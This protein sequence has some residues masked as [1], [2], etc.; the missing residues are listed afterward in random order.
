LTIVRSQKSLRRRMRFMDAYE[1]F[2]AAAE[3][4][5]LRGLIEA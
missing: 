5:A 4:G 2:G 3:T 1:T